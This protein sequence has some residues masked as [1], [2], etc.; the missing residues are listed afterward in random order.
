MSKKRKTK[1]EREAE[2][3][4]LVSLAAFPQCRTCFAFSDNEERATSKEPDLL[5]TAGMCRRHPPVYI[6]DNKGVPCFIQPDVLSSDWCAEY[7]E[8]AP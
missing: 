6:G 7:K 2:H 3:A 1:K 8:A 4:E 5:T